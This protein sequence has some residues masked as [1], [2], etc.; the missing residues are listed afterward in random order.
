[1]HRQSIELPLL[2]FADSHFDDHLRASGFGELQARSVA[3]LQVTP[4]VS[5]ARIFKLMS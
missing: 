3:T 2:A 4:E 1:M 5:I